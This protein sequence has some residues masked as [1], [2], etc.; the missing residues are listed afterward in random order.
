MI[1]FKNKGSSSVRVRMISH[2]WCGLRAWTSVNFYV[3]MSCFR[4]IM[5]DCSHFLWFISCKLEW[6]SSNLLDS[7]GYYFITPTP[8]NKQFY[9]NFIWMGIEFNFSYFQKKLS[10]INAKELYCCWNN[11]QIL[12]MTIS[13][14]FH[15]IT[16]NML[17]NN[18]VLVA[19]SCYFENVTFM[20]SN[21]T[22]QLKG[23][24]VDFIDIQNHTLCSVKKWTFY[25]FQYSSVKIQILNDPVR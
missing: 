6:I 9:Q 25:N 22:Y 8:K 3:R 23:T 19:T 7:F 24:S 20:Y 15:F 18:S 14:T 4:R 12:Q 2:V 11:C 16:T 10:L 1:Y 13:A 5:C 17:P 21:M